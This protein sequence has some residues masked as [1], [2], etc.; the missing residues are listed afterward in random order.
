LTSQ[1]QH[2]RRKIC[3]HDPASR[4]DTS[5][6]RDGWF[7]QP[8]CDVEH[9]LTGLYVGNFDKPVTD[10]LGCLVPDVRPLYS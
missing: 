2:A 9:V 8:C 5:S 4:T 7:A 3:G 1:F 10:M 6:G